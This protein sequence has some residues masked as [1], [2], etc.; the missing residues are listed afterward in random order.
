MAV[1]PPP[2]TPPRRAVLRWGLGDAVIAFFL[3]ILGGA[4]GSE[5]AIV[6][7]GAKIVDGKIPETAAILAGTVIGQYGAWLAWI[8]MA[9]R[10]KGFGSLRADFGLVVDFVHDWAMIPLGVGFEIVAGIVLLPISHLVHHAPQQVVQDLNTSHGAK[11]AVLAVTALLVAPVVEEL[12]FRG[13][14]LRSLQ[15]RMSA[16]AAVAVSA[17]AFGLAHVVFDFGSG[18]V[19]PALVALGMLSG[20]FAVRTGNLSRS[21]LL[22]MGFNLLAVLLVLTNR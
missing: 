17:L 22:H 18:V 9:S 6:A 10:I 16:P 3:G 20:V 12:F 19:L 4:I 11:L 21:I 13:L 2:G 8:Y 15:R 5:I 14:L 7:T 1:P